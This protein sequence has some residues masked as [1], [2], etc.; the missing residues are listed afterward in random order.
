[1]I[2]IK[3]EFIQK[4]KAALKKSMSED[5]E[6]IEKIDF[7][8]S[9]S[10]DNSTGD[11]GLPLFAAA[12]VLH[13][14]PAS[15]AAEVSSFID[16]D[17]LGE[18]LPSGPYLNLKI[19][20]EKYI[21]RLFQ[22]LSE[23]GNDFASVGEDGKKHLEGERVMVE[24]SS[25]NTNKPLHL[26][27]LRN[28]ALGESVSRILKKAGAEVYKVDLVN[29]R[30]IH[31]CKSML[32]YKLFH[33]KKGET[34][35]TLGMKGD[36]FVG[37][38]YV[39]YSNYEKEHPE[40]AK[41]AESLLIKWEEKDE[42]VYALWEKMREWAFS[43]IKETYAKTDVSFDKY[44]FESE[45]YLKGKKIIQ[46][47]LER[48]IFFRA[49]DG[50]VRVDVT[51]A[52]GEARDGGKQEKVLLRSDGTSVY[53]TQDI[54][55]A[56]SRREDFPFD[57][58]VYVVASEQNYHFKVLF[59]LLNLLGYEWAKKL[60]HLSYGLV[61]LPNGRMKSR[62]GTVV[63]ADDLL[64]ELKT[65]ALK[66]IRERGREEEVTD[67]EDV[68]KKVALSAVHYYLLNVTPLKDMLFKAE[69]SLSFNG[70]TGP[71][72]QYMCARI[73]SVS[74][75][76]REEGLQSAVTPEK[77][78]GDAEWALIKKIGEYPETLRK[79]ALQKDPSL[80][81]SYV[82]AAAKLFAKFYQ[83]CPIVGE[84]KSDIKKA[85]SRLALS[86]AALFVLRDASSLL[87]IPFLQAM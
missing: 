28:D 22:E 23:K 45:T 1:M 14:S 34:P 57:S 33:E 83:D 42:E 21:S 67:A 16:T 72:I 25:P 51:Q 78:T 79:A 56:V 85:Q 44:Y 59:Y 87:L 68:A 64:S 52:V 8:V 41:E 81:C 30:G 76:A 80:L 19:N 39:E 26:G 53:I 60:T 5:G 15:L 4:V 84:M 75:K 31:I 77:L 35:E 55:T 74:K 12:K 7:T 47:A 24:F 86:E 29:D 32:A 40:I 37:K 10:P 11:I 49:E 36:H 70:N 82:Y 65:M 27:H 48:G 20:R 9:S 46:D 66:E 61:N 62:E 58:L 69:E 63:D 3:E 2:D 17:D 6:L 54:G 13:V 38:C 71:Y 73:V 50:S 43:G 18:L